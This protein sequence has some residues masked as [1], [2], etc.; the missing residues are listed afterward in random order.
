MDNRRPLDIIEDLIKKRILGGNIN[1]EQKEKD[2]DYEDILE[3]RMGPGYYEQK[4]TLVEKRTD[5]G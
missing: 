2:I 1:P 5:V 4:H 3:M